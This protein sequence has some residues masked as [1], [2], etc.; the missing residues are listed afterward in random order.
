M[1]FTTNQSTFNSQEVVQVHVVLWSDLPTILCPQSVLRRM[2]CIFEVFPPGIAASTLSTLLHTLKT[3]PLRMWKV[4]VL[5]PISHG[6]PKLAFLQL[7]LLQRKIH[8]HQ[9]VKQIL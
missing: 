9:I 4:R 1:Q 2:I 7:P 5:K 3:E 6:S 8:W